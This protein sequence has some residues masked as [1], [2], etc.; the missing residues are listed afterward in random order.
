QYKHHQLFQTI[1]Q[2]EE[3]ILNVDL[4]EQEINV[5]EEMVRFAKVVA[6]VKDILEKTDADLIPQGILDS[7]NAIL[8][9]P[10]NEI[11]TF[12]S[13]K[14][15]IHLQTANQNADQLLQTVVNIPYIAKIDANYFQAATDSYQKIINNYLNNT[16]EHKDKFVKDLDKKLI[17]FT[18]RFA[19]IDTKLQEQNT[20]NAKLEKDFST[21][22]EGIETELSNFR[23]RVDTEQA[24]LR[25]GIETE[26]A[27]LRK[28]IEAEQTSLR[29]T[30]E[31]LSTSFQTKY[32]ELQEQRSKEFSQKIQ[33]LQKLSDIRVI[34]D[35]K[36]AEAV[37]AILEEYEEQAEQV[38][39]TVIRTSQA[40]VYKLD[41]I[42]QG[43][44][45]KFFRA[46]A[47]TFMLFAVLILV[48][49]SIF[50]I[51]MKGAPNVIV[52]WHDW[53][54][55][56]PISLV[57]FFPAFYFARESTRYRNSERK[58]KRLEQILSTIDPYLELL[59]GKRSDSLKNDL[60]A[61]LAE[62]I[63]DPNEGNVHSGDDEIKSILPHVTSLIA[64][65]KKK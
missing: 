54:K 5:Q 56:L 3:L 30:L 8:Q 20:A 37:M 50:E 16:K 36:A 51:F 24:T 52:D 12:A 21:L 31:A 63:F 33:E 10:K 7:I 4:S 34:E 1:A 29:Q 47:S 49:P 39:G 61:T 48:G 44:G 25:Q 17:D 45:E 27:T 2:V 9:G 15:F 55:R 6:F 43:K 35:V 57:L 41:A 19:E 28:G 53:L 13:D 64:A 14:N 46:W 59:D 38:L 32:T 26:Q 62:K 23:Q 42:E 60:K 58:S 18:T 11:T 40:G 65:L 22:K